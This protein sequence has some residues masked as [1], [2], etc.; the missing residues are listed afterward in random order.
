[1]EKINF[2]ININASK[3]KVWKILWDDD[4]YTK[5]TSVFAEGSHAVTDWKEGSKVLFLDGKGSGMVSKIESKKP[6]DFMSFKHVGEVKDN[7][8]DTTSEKVKGWAGALENYSL[9]EKDG[10]TTLTV[11]MDIVDEYKDYFLKTFPNGLQQI[12]TLSE[13]N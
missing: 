5:W 10:A 3:E 4:T 8:E 13:N 1:M 12:K 7:V 6:N 2:S 9:K 11:D